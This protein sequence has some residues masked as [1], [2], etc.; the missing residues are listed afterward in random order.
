M[1]YLWG[2]RFVGPF[3]PLV[4]A[5]RQEL[6]TQ[7]YASIHWSAQRTNINP[8]DVYSPQHPVFRSLCFCL[9]YYEALP[10][11]PGLSSC[12]PLREKAL[13][14]AYAQVVYADEDSGYQTIG[15]VSKAFN[16][17]VRYAKEG[18]ESDAFKAH[19]SRVGDFLWLSK[20]GLMMMGTNG[21]QL[22]DTAFMAQA[23][24]ETGLAEEEDNRESLLGMLDWLDKCQIRD[25]PKWYKQGYR[26]RSKGAWP[27]STPEQSF[28]A[29]IHFVLRSK[30]DEAG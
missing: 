22:W 15:P 1:S 8:I 9:G 29:S 25:N 18:A 26:H 17:V 27:F 28:T 19:L 16:M 20:V 30:A 4:H 3:T 23:L 6:Y 12:L 5:L 2:T 21:S 7:P 11:I 10:A 14:A 13:K 24:V